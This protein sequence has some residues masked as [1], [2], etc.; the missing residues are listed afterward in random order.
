MRLIHTNLIL[1][2]LHRE[3]VILRLAEESSSGF[4]FNINLW[5]LSLVSNVKVDT[6]TNLIPRI[7]I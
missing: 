7:T 6:S 4:F 3:N 2:L 5:L 1:N